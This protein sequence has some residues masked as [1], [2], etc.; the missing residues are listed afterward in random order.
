[1]ALHGERIGLP[2][3][4]IL[5]TLPEGSSGEVRVVYHDVFQREMVQKT[6]STLGLEDSVA[7]QE[8]QLLD[9]IDHPRIVR[10]REAQH[11]PDLSDAVTLVMEYLPEG[12]I[13]KAMEAGTRFGVR[14]ALRIAADVL[15]A[16][17]HLHV[18]VGFL[19]RDVK[20]GNALLAD[21]GTRGLL[22]DLGSAAPFDA[23]GSCA[24][25][26]GTLL[27]R[28][29]EFA[30]GSLDARG[31]VYAVGVM[32]LEM[33]NGP[34]PYDEIDPQAAERSLALGRRAFPERLVVFPPHV[35]ATVSRT[36]RGLLARDPSR[37]PRSAAV[38]AQ[39]IRDCKAI[40]WTHDE[41]QDLEGEWVGAGL[42]GRR[43]QVRRYRVI[44]RVIARG[45]SR[46]SRRVELFYRDRTGASWRRLV[47]PVTSSEP[48]AVREVFAVAHN[49]AFQR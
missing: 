11:D 17:D 12:S 26:G 27:Y 37:W 5:R 33:L 4:A 44:S 9:R 39:Q 6:I 40:D 35:P 38:A 25:Q 46:G 7:H 10:I 48:D 16:L 36:I 21:G 42:P 23:T 1:V 34:L 18:T 13:G 41:G 49:S 22:T 29:P 30:R 8:P 15:D 47:P 20:P 14:Q 24:A 31:D 45:P 43:G 19:H 28:P 3:Y 32:L 2:T